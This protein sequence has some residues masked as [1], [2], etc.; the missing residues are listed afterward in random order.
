MTEPAPPRDALPFGAVPP[1]QRANPSRLAARAPVAVLALL[2]FGIALYLAL[3]QYHV[4][5]AVWDPIFGS[6]SERVLTSALSRALPV[7]DA[8]LGATAYLVEFVLEVSGG[9]RRWH[10]HP[11]LVVL[12]GLTAAGLA[13][14]GVL[15]VVSQPVLT[16]TFC[17]LCLCSAAV[18]FVVAGLVRRE[19][20]ATVALVR[21]RRRAGRS[22]P[23]ALSGRQQPGAGDR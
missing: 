3:F 6:G 4:V 22:L 14:V 8:A 5:G 13:V 12:L 15:L 18:S 1:G 9:Q 21:R 2:G 7:S 16:G 23:A 10:D 19:V 20:L 11:W 17:T